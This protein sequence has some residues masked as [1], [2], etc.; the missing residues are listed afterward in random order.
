M[1]LPALLKDPANAMVKLNATLIPGLKV[2]GIELHSGK[3]PQKMTVSYNVV[4]A[5]QLFDDE[6]KRLQS[7]VDSREYS[8]EKTRKGKT[9][10]IDIRPLVPRLSINDDKSLLIDMISASA[11]PGVKVIE[12]VTAILQL[13]KEDA[14]AAKIVKTGW[15]QVDCLDQ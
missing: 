4:L 15:Q 12:A 6:K 8:I 3:V 5:R 1:D 10:T 11:Q 7:F 13:T 9:K 2:T 14:L